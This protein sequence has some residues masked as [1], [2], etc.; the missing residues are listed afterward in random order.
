MLRPALSLTLP[1]PPLGDGFGVRPGDAA[2]GVYDGSFA[3]DTDRDDLASFALLA[4][5]VLL[6]AVLAGT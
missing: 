5:G 6:A 4:A 1:Q 2:E 3:N